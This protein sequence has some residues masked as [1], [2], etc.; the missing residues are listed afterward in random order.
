MTMHNGFHPRSNVYPVYIPRKKGC[1]RPLGVEDTVNLAVFGIER[2]VGSSEER[3]INA[4][5]GPRRSDEGREKEFQ[6]RVKIERK[7]HL[8][9]KALHGQS[10]YA[11]WR[12]NNN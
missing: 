1:R 12:N 2:Y 7:Q 11:H 4:A 10:F 5:R 9:N 3:L 8:N 6:K